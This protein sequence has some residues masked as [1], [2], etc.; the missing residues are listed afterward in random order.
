MI[1]LWY[2]YLIRPRQT[3]D[4]ENGSM[5][6]GVGSADCAG[7]SL[8]PVNPIN[9]SNWEPTLALVLCLSEPPAAF[10]ILLS[11]KNP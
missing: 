4:I 8:T 2:K 11:H 6:V 1:L 9:K 3:D 7:G 10:L 5:S